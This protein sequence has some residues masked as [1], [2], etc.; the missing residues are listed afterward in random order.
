[1]EQQVTATEA[2]DVEQQNREIPPVHP[3][4]HPFFEQDGIVI[5]HGRCEDVLPTIGTVDAIVT[6]PP[7]LT[8]GEGVPI[9]KTG[10]NGGVAF[11][12]EQ[13]RAVGVPWGY[14]LDW[15]ELAKATSPKHW[16]VFANY[17]ML[18]G[19]CT[20]LEPQTV[21]V[22]RKSNAPRMTRPVPRLD[23]E[24][25]V[26]A[27]TGGK[28]DRMG[29]FD[30]MVLD[31]PMPQAGYMAQERIIERNTGKAVHPCQKPIAVVR[32][33]VDRLDAAIVCDPFMGTGTTLLAAKLTGRRAVGIEI[34]ERYCEIAANRLR[35]GVLPFVG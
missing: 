16:I 4:V 17:K 21:F 14:T 22:W 31:V 29:E 24:F 23:C 5:Y 8:G 6:D 19:L 13:S 28:C 20:A 26:W 2:N 30:T 35:Q 34:E 25:I 7:Y 9:G 11:V 18:G 12:Y 1:M 32:P 3:I 15:I 33:F 10:K 27:R